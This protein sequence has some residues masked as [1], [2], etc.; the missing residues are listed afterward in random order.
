MQ[1]PAKLPDIAD[2]Q[3]VETHE[4]DLDLSALSQGNSALSSGASVRHESKSR[5]FG[6]AIT[7]E[8]S[9]RRGL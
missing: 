6:P 8:P 7:S 5:D 9:R 4:A 1:L 2:P 3:R